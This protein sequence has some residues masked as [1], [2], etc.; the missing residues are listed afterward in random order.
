MKMSVGKKSDKKFRLVDLLVIL[1]CL[2]GAAFCIKL[3][4]VDLF[5]T[6][7][8]QNKIPIG[9]VSIKKNT[10]QRRVADRVLWDRLIK[11]SPV[12]SGDLIRVADNSEADLIVGGNSIA[13][14]E[15]TLVR[16]RYNKETGEFQIDLSSGNLELVTA[17]EGGNV[18]LNIMDHQVEAAPGTSLNASAGDDGMVLQVSKGEAAIIEEGRIRELTPGTAVA[19]DSGGSII[20]APSVFVIQP[21]PN[22]MYRKSGEL[23]NVGFSWNRINFQPNEKLRLEIAEDQNFTRSVRTL[24]RLDD[25]ARTALSTGVWNWRLTYNNVVMD[26]GRFTILDAPGEELLSPARNRQI[27]FDDELP[28]VYFQWPQTDD[29]LHYIVEVD[30]TEE[31]RNPVI[32]R[33]TTATSFS[34]SSLGEGIWYWRVTPVYSQSNANSVPDSHPSA[35]RIVKSKE[36][37]PLVFAEEPAPVTASAP[38][39]EPVPPPAPPPPAPVRR[40]AP[41]PPAP[42]PPPAPPPPAPPPPAPVAPPAPV[43]PPA[44]R[45][46]TLESPTNGTTLAGL[47]ALRQQTIFRWSSNEAVARSRFVLSRNSNPLTGQAVIEILDPNRTIRLDGIE[48]GIWYWTVEAQTPEGVNISA[49]TPRQLRVLPIPL[50][51]APSDRQPPEGYRVDIEELKKVTIN[52]IWSGV[53]GANAYIFTLYQDVGSGRRQITQIGPENITSWATDVK[54]L[55]RGNFIWR[56]EAVNVGR[57]N[58]IEQHGNPAES[59]F[60]VDIPPAG[61]VQIIDGPEDWP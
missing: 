25:S 43:P 60:D 30:V 5:Q 59:R 20:S 6:I 35:F 44:P 38:P 28:K 1:L 26:S 19:I 21:K 42:V 61:P 12:Y 16:L 56:V 40:P 33:M 39:P 11:E 34:D 27:S 49:Q 23:F 9:I 2:L 47:T 18:I 41:P 51:P 55:G 52:F 22:A 13:L 17:S 54:T 10:V 58:V 14:N 50:L 7:N 24:D 8:G 37:L 57:N 45:R 3:F 31:F 46:V 29:V 4:W 48:E 53:Q 32:R 15:N 36:P